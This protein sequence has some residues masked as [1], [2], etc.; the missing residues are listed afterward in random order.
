MKITNY[1][2]DKIGYIFI[3]IVLMI[4]IYIVLRMS[5]VNNLI[6]ILVLSI[7][8]INDLVLLSSYYKKKVF[9]NNFIKTLNKLDK[10]YLITEMINECNFNEGKILIDTLYEIDKSMHEEINKYKYNS[11]EFREYIDLWCHEIKTPIATLKLILENNKA[12]K[13]ILEE[14]ERIENYVEQ[15][16]YYSKSDNVNDDYIIKNINLEDIIDNVVKRNKKDLINKKIKIII[17]NNNEVKSDSKW[18]EFIVNQIISNSI[19]YSKD[20]NAYIKIISK[21]NKNNILLMIEDNG[22]GIES[23]ELDKVFDKGYTGTNGRKKYNSTG[24]G[25]YLCKKLCL[26][27]GHEIYIDS[28]INEKT[29]VTIIF[30]N[31]SMQ[32]L[33]NM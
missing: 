25:L 11:I 3:S 5:N 31:S 15:V 33:T 12:N 14:V 20:K 6:I 30:P 8:L 29:I 24:I 18:L 9:Y 22:I 32:N 23:E 10:K 27:L 4:C 13:D 7:I 19:K 21:K 17:E 28:K 26:K 16:L 1:I 2:K